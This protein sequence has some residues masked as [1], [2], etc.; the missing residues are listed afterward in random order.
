VQRKGKAVKKIYFSNGTTA[1]ASA[2]T[3]KDPNI[4]FTVP[5][6]SLEAARD[7]F[8]A[9]ASVRFAQDG[10]EYA[11]LGIRGDGHIKAVL[12]RP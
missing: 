11:M 9:N 2:I 8:K 1:D 3:Q 12:K 4:T 6:A 10:K 5:M 7:A